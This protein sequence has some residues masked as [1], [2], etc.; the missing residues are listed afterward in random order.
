MVRGCLWL[1]LYFAK[2]GEE[3]SSGQ[4]CVYP[5]NYLALNYDKYRI[6]IGLSDKVYHNYSAG[7]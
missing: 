7:E 2:F 3:R 6:W 4:A 5:H 1:V